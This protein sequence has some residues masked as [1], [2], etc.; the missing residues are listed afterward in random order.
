MNYNFKYYLS[1]SIGWMVSSLT[2]IIVYR[3]I[4]F[5]NLALSLLPLAGVIA[6]CFLFGKDRFPS[7]LVPAAGIIF[8]NTIFLCRLASH[9]LID[10]MSA[11]AVV[12]FIMMIVFMIKA[13]ATDQ[14]STFGIR[15]P[16]TLSH[17]EVWSRTH[18]FLSIIIAGFLPA[19]FL[20]IFFW[21]NWGRFWSSTALVILPLSISSIYANIIGRPYER[22]EAEARENQ[23]RN[24]QGYRS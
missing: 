24:E 1:V 22:A 5:I 2:A 11:T 8:F 4:N 23:I 19:S 12:F 7:V 15:A 3:E 9:I 6:C 13:P 21:C 14:N 17:K 10:L 20:L 18:R 16:I